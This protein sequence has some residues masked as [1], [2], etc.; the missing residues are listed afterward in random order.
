MKHVSALAALA[1]ALAACNT[2]SN[3]SPSQ[4]SNATYGPRDSFTSIWTL[5]QAAAINAKDDN[6]APEIKQVPKGNAKTLP[7]YHVWDTWPVRRLD[8]STAT[9]NGWN[10]LVHL[11]VPDTVLPG[12]R[13]DIAQLRWSYARDGRSWKLGGL[14]FPDAKGGTVPG[15]ELGSR[16]WAG[17]AILTMD[18]KVFVYYTV[19]GVKGEN[20]TPANAP[21]RAQLGALASPASLSPQSGCGYSG[22]TQGIS[23]EQKIAVA[24][25]PTLV[26]D[27]NG[28][29]FEGAWQHKVILEADGKFYQTQAQADVGPLNAFRD[30]FVFR[31]PKDGR[32]Y[33]LLEG[34][35]GGASKSTQSCKPEEIG[36]ASFRAGVQVPR[37]AAW[38]NGNVGLAAAVN[39]D[40]TTWELLPPLL[41]ANCVNQELERP[42]FVF[43]DGKYYLFVSSHI[44]KF[45]PFPQLA[46]KGF[47]GLLG[48]VSDSLRGTYRP[49]NGSG[50]VLSNPTSQPYQAYSFDVLSN[51]GVYP[52]TSFI[53]TP[54]AK[55]IGAEGGLPG[56]Q[57]LARFG[58]TL[59]PTMQLYLEG[60]RAGI[61]NTWERG[62]I[63]PTSLPKN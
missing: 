53:D 52:V 38:H 61:R 34:N 4:P 42:H 51:A 9:V 55:D 63:R 30:P 26:A 41:S 46:G 62:D 17:S 15:V 48:F 2:T 33:M 59:A 57:Q 20:V 28:V 16:N 50:L 7:G 39:D 27:D 58:G 3:P 56:D 37:E 36:D 10:V 21:A 35:T 12:K 5:Q 6:I 32:L 60:D 25:G 31:D 24:F 49:L 22:C 43:K 47:E 29:R 19:T 8:S 13:H 40:L 18:N 45:A 44:T 23:Y 1:I 14:L 11:S 54:P